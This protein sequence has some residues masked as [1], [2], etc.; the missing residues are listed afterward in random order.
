MNYTDQLLF[1]FGAIGV[2][3]SILVSLYFIFV[4]KPKVNT[5]IL[6]GIFLLFLSE[7]ALR[8]LV[9][10]FS[11]SN[12]NG[13]SSFGPITFIFIGPFLFHYVMSAL[14]INLPYKK[15][16][17]GHISFWVLVAIGLHF[18]MPF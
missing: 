14:K 17:Y 15:F 2:F 12:A 6:F 18:F 16:I 13:Y 5:N 7:R 4:K 1:F 10:F 3:N 9:Y 11:D 8:A